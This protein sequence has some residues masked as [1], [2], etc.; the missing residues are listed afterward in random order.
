MDSVMWQPSENFVR[1]YHVVCSL[2]MVLCGVVVAVICLNPASF[3][4][5]Y[6]FLVDDR[7]ALV[8]PYILFIVLGEAVFSI[9]Y[10]LFR[11]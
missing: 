8:M 10:F 4:S 9:W 1:K 6:R 2:A 11:K 5:V 3:P 7:I